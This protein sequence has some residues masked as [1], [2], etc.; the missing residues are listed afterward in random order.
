MVKNGVQLLKCL[1]FLSGII[2][3]TLQEIRKGLE[4]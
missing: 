4:M 1:F 2:L 3:T